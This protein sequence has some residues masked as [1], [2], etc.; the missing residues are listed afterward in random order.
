MTVFGFRDWPF[1][2]VTSPERGENLWADRADALKQV[3]AILDDWLLTQRSIINLMWADLGAGKTHTL[4]NL[5]AR[6]EKT[7]RLL[8]IYVL[9]PATITNFLGLYAAIARNIDWT[10]VGANLPNSKSWA[11]TSLKRVCTWLQTDVDL[12]RHNH[13]HRWLR[14]DRLR[15]TECQM[16]G[17]ASPITIPEDAVEVLAVAVHALNATGV[18]V[19]LMIDE[20]QRVAEGKRK[21][22]QDIGH[23]IHT[24]YNACPN[25]FSLVL[26]CAT[27]MSDDVA[28][29]LTPEI[30]SRLSPKRIELNYLTVD[31][32]ESYIRDLFIFYRADGNE[33]ELFPLSSEIIREFGTFLKNG[34]NRETTPRRI[35]EA[36][37]QLLSHVRH[38][39]IS[40]P[41]TLEAF[42]RW[43]TDNGTNLVSRIG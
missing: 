15:A 13:A 8:P 3:E 24:L 35:N 25:N 22:L 37:D 33:D 7:N 28:M 1:S 23:G 16:L 5:K 42:K 40:V 17:V 27:G 32:I 39:Q 12:V 19:V 36:F 29:I 20:Y 18:R 6:C 34:L 14:G 2:N 26:S 38:E 11:V 21:Q 30:V 10:K 4:Y 41:L 31:N 43:L 9:L